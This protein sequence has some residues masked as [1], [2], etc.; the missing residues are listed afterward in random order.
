MTGRKKHLTPQ[1][2][3]GEQ[4]FYSGQQLLGVVKR[5]PDGSWAVVKSAPTRHANRRSPRSAP[6]P[7]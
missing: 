4:W 2:R 1:P 6:S 3:L 5:Q 7:R